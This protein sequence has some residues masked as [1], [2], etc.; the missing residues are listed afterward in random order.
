M[1]G[2]ALDGADGEQQR[3]G[4]A[5]LRI[6]LELAAAKFKRMPALRLGA[7]QDVLR[8]APEAALFPHMGSETALRAGNPCCENAATT[9]RSR[10]SKT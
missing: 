9:L 7:Q 1:H 3:A 5:E 2:A 6:N 8:Q 10:R 4:A